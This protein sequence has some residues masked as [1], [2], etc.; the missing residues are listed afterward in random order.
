MLKNFWGK[1]DCK[2]ADRFRYSCL[3]WKMIAPFEIAVEFL[4]M[5]GAFE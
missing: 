2:A 5:I 1:V 3:G 4:K